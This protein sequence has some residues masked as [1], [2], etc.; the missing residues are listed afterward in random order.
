MS[1]QGWLIRWLHQPLWLRLSS[2]A[3]GSVLLALALWHFGV[4]P[5]WREAEALASQR[6]Q[7]EQRYQ[8]SLRALL[9]Q[10]PLQ[11][12]DADIVRLQQALLPDKRQLLS[13]PVLI[14]RAGGE[15][16]LWQPAG[17]GGELTIKLRWQGVQAVLH[18]LSRLQS[19]VILPQFTLKAEQ[20]QLH[21]RLILRRAHED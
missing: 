13:L 18:Y 9:H 15:L 12:I 5:L 11:S 10:P 8:G 3:F 4:R 1:G 19:G 16:E 7:Q 21:F 20:E 17:Q 14:A 6:R 2:V